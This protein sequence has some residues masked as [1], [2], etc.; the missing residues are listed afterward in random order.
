MQQYYVKEELALNSLV[1]MDEE[2]SHHIQRVMRMKEGNE[3]I[4]ADELGQQF[5]GNIKY[6]DGHVY[7][8]VREEYAYCE[9][10]QVEIILASALIKKDKWDFLLQKCSELGVSE[11]IPFESSRCVVKMK[12]EK[13]DKKLERWR[14]I[15]SES[16]EQCKRSKPVVLNEVV[17]F[18]QLAKLEADIKLVAYEDC[19]YPSLT[20][21]E[22]LSQYQ[23]VKR[24]IVVVGCEGGFDASEIAY[25]QDN[26]Y[27]S[28]TLGKRI[29]RAETAAM[30]LVDRIS[31][32]YDK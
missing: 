32:Y 23:D 2:Q 27:T 25:L 20:I 9:D 16:G 5:Y 15:L 1:L 11:I 19:S 10:D 31:F 7:V 18:K 21:K 29:L 4:V 28:I 30:A 24:I 13:S 3:V 12:D 17:S 6:V 26:G 14:K 22:V 8:E